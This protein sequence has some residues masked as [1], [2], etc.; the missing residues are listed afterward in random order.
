MVESHEPWGDDDFEHQVRVTAYY[1]W[2]HDGRPE[3]REQDFWYRALEQ[4]LRR[5]N[6]DRDLRQEPSGEHEAYR[7]PK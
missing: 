7:G 1:M 4:C 6:A 5:R 3:G 2:E